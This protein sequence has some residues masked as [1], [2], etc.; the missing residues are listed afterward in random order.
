MS[1]LAKKS[2]QAALRRMPQTSRL[3]LSQ[4]SVRSASY[5]LGNEEPTLVDLLDDPVTRYVMA[6]DGI[7]RDDLLM[8]LEDAKGKLGSC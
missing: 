3:T 1:D 4:W 8:V 7:A 6:S 2:A 5:F